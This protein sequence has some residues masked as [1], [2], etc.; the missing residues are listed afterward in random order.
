VDTEPEMDEADF[1]EP[2]EQEKQ[3]IIEDRIKPVQTPPVTADENP[4]QEIY[5]T[6][7][8]YL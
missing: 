5:K 1:F 4:P 7:T 3:K 2:T 8:G 6:S